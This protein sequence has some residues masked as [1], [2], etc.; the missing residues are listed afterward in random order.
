MKILIISTSFGDLSDSHTIRIQNM[1]SVFGKQQLFF[2]GCASGS[3]CIS[4]DRSILFPMPKIYRWINKLNHNTFS[5]KILINFYR[6]F[7]GDVFYGFA[8]ITQKNLKLSTFD[9]SKFDIVIS[10]S[11]SIES[12][13]LAYKISKAYNLPHVMDYGDPISPLA[14]GPYK[15]LNFELEKKMLHNSKLVTFTTISTKKQYLRIFGPIN[16]NVIQYGSPGPIRKTQKNR[17]FKVGYF[18]AAFPGDRDLTNLIKVIGGRTDVELILAGRISNRFLQMIPIHTNISYLGKLSYEKSLDE[19]A[20]LDLNVIVGNK[21]GRQLPGKVFVSLSIMV[22]I[23]YI[24][25]C[26]NGNDEAYQ[27]LSKFEG[28]RYVKNDSFYIKQAID[29]EIEHPADMISR[30]IDDISKEAESNKLKGL[31]CKLW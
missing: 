15:L 9:P 22:P 21:D 30:N 27:L 7:F 24:E 14:R 23:L 18:G 17:T 6:Y 29:N 12:H 10:S 20:K 3:K 4:A 28:V 19:Q 16:S 25:Q 11:G 8:K 5:F 13:K 31:L 1:L 26:D 2:I